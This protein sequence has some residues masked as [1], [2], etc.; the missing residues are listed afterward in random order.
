MLRACS[1][2]LLPVGCIT[3]TI[4]VESQT[5]ALTWGTLARPR[6]SHHQNSYGVWL[7][8][9]TILN[10]ENTLPFTYSLDIPEHSLE[11]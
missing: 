6:A 8:V 4:L 10:V 9:C 2:T 1:A 5:I 3:C 7:E 11:S